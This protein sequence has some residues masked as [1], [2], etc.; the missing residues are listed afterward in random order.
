MLLHKTKASVAVSLLPLHIVFSQQ[1]SL[2]YL[3]TNM[4]TSC[5][6]HNFDN[7]MRLLYRFDEQGEAHVY[8]IFAPSTVV[9]IQVTGQDEILQVVKS[10]DPLTLP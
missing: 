4:V 3:C 7:I 1:I 9:K 10:Q 5:E 6:L 8:C 2:S